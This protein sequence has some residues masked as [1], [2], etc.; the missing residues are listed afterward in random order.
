MALWKRV[1]CAFALAVIVTIPLYA[2][3]VASGTRTGNQTF[4]GGNF[5]LQL[6]NGGPPSIAFS[7]K[8]VHTISFSAECETSGD[9]LSIQ[10]VLDL[11]PLAPTAGTSDA[12]C[13]DH[14]DND[15]LDGFTTAHY[16][17]VTP[18]LTAGV[19]VVQVLGSVVG[20]LNGGGQATGWIG[21][22][23]VIVEK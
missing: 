6:S 4:H 7:G 21:D 13:S 9:W 10:I 5:A 20:T 16:R 15:S 11:Q 12:F 23:V 1:L 3:V 14:N 8:G 17:V 2:K 19:H 22:S 18:P